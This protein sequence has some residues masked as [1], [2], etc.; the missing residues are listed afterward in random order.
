MLQVVDIMGIQ[1]MA[2]VAENIT[3]RANELTIWP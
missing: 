3:F 1:N 2:G